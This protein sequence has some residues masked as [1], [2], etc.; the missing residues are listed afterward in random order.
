MRFTIT[1]L[2][3]VGF[4]TL[5]TNRAVS[6]IHNETRPPGPRDRVAHFTRN[7]RFTAAMKGMILREDQALAVDGCPRRAPHRGFILDI[8]RGGFSS[9]AKGYPVQIIQFIDHL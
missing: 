2:T 8:D 9:Q 6:R 7:W 4:S 5:N 3:T 1:R